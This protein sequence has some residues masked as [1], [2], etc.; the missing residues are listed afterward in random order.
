M[1]A[2]ARTAR[3]GMLTVAYPADGRLAASIFVSI[4]LPAPGWPSSSSGTWVAWVDSRCAAS[5]SAR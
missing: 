2:C 3:S 4:D 1:E 5:R